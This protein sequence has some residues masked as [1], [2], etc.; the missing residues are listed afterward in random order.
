MTSPSVT[1]C[2][3]VW[4][5]KRDLERLLPVLRGQ[6]YGGEWTILATDSSS[7]DGSLDVLREAGVE[8]EVIAQKDFHHARTRQALAQRAKSDLVVFLSQDAL[9]DGPDFLA[10]LVAPLDEEGVAGVCARVLP[11][12]GDDPLT[13]RTA[14]SLREAEDRA[15]RFDDPRQDPPF[16]DVASA[17]RTEILEALPFPD[18][19]FGEDRAWARSALAAGHAIVFEPRATCFHAH[20]YGPVEAFRRYREDAEFHLAEGSG[21]ALRPS[22]F[23]VLRGIAY[24]LREDLRFILRTRPSGGL[25]AIFRAPFLRTAQ[26]LGQY[27]GSRRKG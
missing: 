9:P 27:F 20:R 8:T 21:R 12:S 19:R 7:T 2:L 3:P 13:K 25:Q 24:E 17:M 23:S 26:V 18:V 11:H 5:G 1:I 6:S 10:H 22:L 14:L 16:N 4:N 15:E